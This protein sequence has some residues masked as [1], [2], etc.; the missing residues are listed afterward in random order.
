MVALAS[1]GSRYFLRQMVEPSIANLYFLSHSEM[2]PGVKVVSLGSDSVGRAT[3]RS[4][5]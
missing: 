1:S 4:G 5:K 2:P 3:R